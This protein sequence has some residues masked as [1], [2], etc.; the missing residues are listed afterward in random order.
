MKKKSLLAILLAGTMIFATACGGNGGSSSKN[1]KSDGEGIVYDDN[2]QKSELSTKDYGGKTFQFLY[3]YEPSEYVYRKVATFN[4]VFNANVEI[5]VKTGL[6]DTLAKAVA[7][8]EVYDIIAMHGDYYPELIN[9]DLLEPLDEHIAEVDMYN[10]EKPENGGLSQAVLDSF[11]LNG[12]TYAAGGSNAVYNYIMCYN[13]LLFEKAGLEDPYELYEKGEWTWDKFYEMGTSVTDV[14]SQ[15]GFLGAPGLYEWLTWNCVE[16]VTYDSA[17]GT[18]KENLTST[19]VV[20]AVKMYQEIVIG[21]NPICVTGVT[22]DPFNSGKQY[23]SMVVTDAYSS[24]AD[25]V[26]TSTAFGKDASNM[27]VV[28]VP[29]APLNK[30]GKEPGHAPQGYAASKGCTDTSVAVCYALFES[31]LGD[32]D[33][34]AK[35]QLPSAIRT[36]VEQKFATNGFLTCCGLADSEGRKI[37]DVL[38][39][40]IRVTLIKGGDVAAVLNAN[41]SVFDRLIN[42]SM[43]GN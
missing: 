10:S 2:A 25:Q 9:A 7:G 34:G 19:D 5:V 12:K 6:K 36:A 23:M 38:N 21:D 28:P 32:A 16:T 11:K 27:G 4:K 42:D 35:N 40:D 15:I 8:G 18:F 22:G 20:E 24:L 31:R 29:T 14:A 43:G 3:W 30:T 33:T 37:T 17:T 26:A 13:K 41:R 1:N 39:K